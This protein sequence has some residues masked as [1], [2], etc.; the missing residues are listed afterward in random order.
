MTPGGR[1]GLSPE[2]SHDPRVRSEKMYS[3]RGG[4]S[5]P[6]SCFSSRRKARST[7]ALSGPAPGRMRNRSSRPRASAGGNSESWVSSPASRTTAR[8]SGFISASSSRALAL[9]S[10]SRLTPPTAY[11]MLAL[12][13]NRSAATTGRSPAEPARWANSRGRASARHRATRTRMRSSKSSRCWSC[14]FRW[15]ILRR[16]LRKRK[17]GKARRFGF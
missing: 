3:S 9:A 16:C 8:L 14:I 15:L 12:V 10:S 6:P 5:S 17:A 13:S 1:V 2:A 4:P 11:S 7:A